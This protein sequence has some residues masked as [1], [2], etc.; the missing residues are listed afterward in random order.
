MPGKSKQ[1]IFPSSSCFLSVC[2]SFCFPGEN[3][4]DELERRSFYSLP[5][6]VTWVLW[7]SPKGWGEGGTPTLKREVLGASRSAHSCSLVRIAAHSCSQSAH[8]CS[9]MLIAARLCTQ[10]AHGCSFVLTVCSWLLTRAHSCSF[11]LTVCSFV[12]TVC[13]WLLTRAHSCS[14]VLTVCS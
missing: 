1:V 6:L 2:R 4:E 12:L 11:V 10:S 9:L 7:G 5:S 8:S 13:S 3:A 14:F